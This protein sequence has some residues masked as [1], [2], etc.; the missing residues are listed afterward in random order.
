MAPK[1]EKEHDLEEFSDYFCTGKNV[2]N[3]SKFYD[4]CA[5]LLCPSGV[6]TPV[7]PSPVGRFGCGGVFFVSPFRICI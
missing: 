2:K 6:G 5:A 7:L 4:F 1:P 3:T